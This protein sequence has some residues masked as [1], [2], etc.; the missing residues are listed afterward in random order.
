METAT[1]HRARNSDEVLLWCGK[2]LFMLFSFT[3]A[4][5]VGIAGYYIFRHIKNAKRSL[6]A[7]VKITNGSDFS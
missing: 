1:T 3:E 5:S 4:M 2:R 6:N 7:V